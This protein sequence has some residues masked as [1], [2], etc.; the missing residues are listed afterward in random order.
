MTSA[1][2]W[3]NKC[4]KSE[5]KQNTFCGQRGV[6][7]PKLLWTSYLEALKEGRQGEAGNGTKQ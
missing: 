2:N 7:N 6:K 1:Q 5:D 3:V 4:S